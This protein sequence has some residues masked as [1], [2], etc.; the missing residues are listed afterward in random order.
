PA[1]PARRRPGRAG[2]SGRPPACRPFA[3]APR[4]PRDPR[5]ADVVASLKREG[6]CAS[7]VAMQTARPPA[8][9]GWVS[10]ARRKRLSIGVR[11]HDLIAVP[12][13]ERP[14]D[15]PGEAALDE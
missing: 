12:G 4:R 10:D 9:N 5:R 3:T 11:A 6:R 14:P 15:R 7:P 2:Q 1:R 13:A 8:W